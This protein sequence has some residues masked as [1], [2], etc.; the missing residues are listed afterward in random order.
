MRKNERVEKD[1]NEREGKGRGLTQVNA[2][3]DWHDADLDCMIS[4]VV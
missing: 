2:D 4:G 3:L 1:K